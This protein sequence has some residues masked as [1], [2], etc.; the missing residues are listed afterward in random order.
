[1]QWSVSC[2][3]KQRQ[4]F[5]HSIYFLLAWHCDITV[6]SEYMCSSAPCHSSKDL[7]VSNHSLTHPYVRSLAVILVP[8]ALDSLTFKFEF[9]PSFV[10]LSYKSF[11]L[12]AALFQ[13][14]VSAWP[15]LPT[16]FISFPSSFSSD[17]SWLLFW[18]KEESYC[19]KN[20]ALKWITQM[21]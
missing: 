2:W 15:H 12:S 11:V 1:M 19:P 7:P 9:T 8:W 18:R 4:W 5:T 17:D 14:T 10:C 20:S 16:C 13:T 3:M 21:P 6:A